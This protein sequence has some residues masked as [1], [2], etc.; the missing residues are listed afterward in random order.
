MKYEK[1]LRAQRVCILKGQVPA[2]RL[3]VPSNSLEK[4]FGEGHFLI[5]IENPLLSSEFYLW[6]SELH[7][8]NDNN[9]YK[10][11]FNADNSNWNNNN[12]NNSNNGVVCL[13]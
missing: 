4:S 13:G 3:R 12:R 6:S 5:R 10:R 2:G 9:A 1:Y 11:N 8:S 7:E